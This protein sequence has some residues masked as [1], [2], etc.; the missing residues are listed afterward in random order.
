MNKPYLPD[1]LA[2]VTKTIQIRWNTGKWLEPSGLLSARLSRCPVLKPRLLFHKLALFQDDLQQKQWM[3][4]GRW[5]NL[6]QKG[7][8]RVLPRERWRSLQPYHTSCQ[9]WVRSIFFFSRAGRASRTGGVERLWHT[10]SGC[11]C[12]S[13]HYALT[14]V[15]LLTPGTKPRRPRSL[16]G[17]IISAGCYTQPGHA[18]KNLS[19]GCEN[20]QSNL[21]WTKRSISSEVIDSAQPTWT[22]MSRVISRCET[23]IVQWLGCV[24]C[25][26]TAASRQKRCTFRNSLHRKPQVVRLR[27]IP[28]SLVHCYSPDTY[29]VY[30]TVQCKSPLHGLGFMRLVVAK[31]LHLSIG[32]SFALFLAKKL[33]LFLPSWMA[34]SSHFPLP[35]TFDSTKQYALP[36]AT[37]FFCLFDIILYNPKGDSLIGSIPLY[38]RQVFEKRHHVLLLQ[39][40]L[41]GPLG[42]EFYDQERGAAAFSL[43]TMAGIRRSSSHPQVRAWQSNPCS[44]LQQKLSCRPRYHQFQWLIPRTRDQK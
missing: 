14:G 3:S 17:L 32:K 31:N 13:G 21:K 10:E 40:P 27:D 2:G 15:V 44:L 18:Q 37:V 9:C 35:K 25:S 22:H 30:Q 26:C 41:H 36:S 6:G 28:T 11:D 1:V 20:I 16:G 43:C 5:N 29:Y 24:A 19:P 34:L 33:H 42:S 39:I 8:R 12:L 38:I 4:T 23:S 7:P